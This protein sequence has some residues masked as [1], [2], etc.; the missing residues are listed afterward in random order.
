MQALDRC[1][2]LR[3]QRVKF[4]LE[5]GLVHLFPSGPDLLR[6]R[7]YLHGRIKTQNTLAKRPWIAGLR[8][9]VTALN[10]GLA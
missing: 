10:T 4:L 6:L 8:E 2:D 7:S 1:R 5:L 3:F 9:A